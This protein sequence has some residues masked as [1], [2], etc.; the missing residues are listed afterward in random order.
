K[1]AWLRLW[2]WVVWHGCMLI[3]FKGPT[4]IRGNQVQGDEDRRRADEC[5]EHGDLESHVLGRAFHGF[6]H[7]LNHNC[8]RNVPAIS[9][10]IFPTADRFFN[11][12][13]VIKRDLP[14]S[15]WNTFTCSAAK[16]AS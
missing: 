4:P 3:H 15:C 9:S 13:R 2:F 10:N 16:A 8:R 11:S 6:F 14:L 1:R 12:A 5:H 7:N